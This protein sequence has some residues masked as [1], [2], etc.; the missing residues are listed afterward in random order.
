M[1]NWQAVVKS[2]DEHPEQWEFS[3]CKI[4]HQ[5]SGIE[6]DMDYMLHI[7]SGPRLQ[8]GDSPCLLPME[9]T[10]YCRFAGGKSRINSDRRTRYGTLQA[11][12]E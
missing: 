9:P 5:S 8:L 10:P 7:D 2:L 11:A 4:V 6:I 3:K 12:P 1:N